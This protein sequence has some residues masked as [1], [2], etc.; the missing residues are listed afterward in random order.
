MV[1]A[2]MSSS[3]HQRPDFRAGRQCR[4]EVHRAAQAIAQRLGSDRWWTDQDV[5]KDFDGA[6][7]IQAPPARTYP[8]C[9][10]ISTR[11][12]S[13]RAAPAPHGSIVLRP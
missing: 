7:A 6:D 1:G 9:P 2:P 12:S 13:W 4:R 5:I 11:T 8:A 3:W 10:A